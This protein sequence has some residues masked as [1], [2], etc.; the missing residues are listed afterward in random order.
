MALIACLLLTLVLPGAA[1]AND[2]LNDAIREAQEN[3][4]QQNQIEGRLKNL[5]VKEKE[6]ETKLLDLNTRISQAVKDL[7]VKESAYLSATR[8]VDEAKAAVE[9]KQRELEARQEALRNRSRAA[10]ED[11]GVSYLAVVFQSATFSDFL[12]RLEYM[13]RVID[14][15][16]YL[17]NDA[18]VQKAELEAE[19]SSLEI[20]MAQAE[21]LKREAEAAKTYLDDSRSRQQEALQENQRDQDE[22]M[23]QMDR[24]EKDSKELEAKIRELQS[25]NLSGVVGSISTWP[26]P[27]YTYITSP[28]AIRTHPITGVV[29]QH[30]GVDIGAA[31]R[32]KILAAGSG[33]VILSS[34]YGAYGNAVIIDHGNGVSSLYGHMSSISA[35]SGQTVVAGQVIGYIGS[36]GYSTG[37][38]LHFEIRIDGSPTDPMPY[39]R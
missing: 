30:T 35:K 28:Y 19:K 10:Y 11:G 38:H 14:A 33:T 37:P 3:Y 6:M 34:W 27:G 7:E 32:S 21:Q 4:R 36:T 31:N 13:D 16:Q 17:L 24:L 8:A 39:F 2:E 20:K 9:R 26:T 15:D 12:T 29:K 22:L 25:R 23:E 5:T 1:A 18:R